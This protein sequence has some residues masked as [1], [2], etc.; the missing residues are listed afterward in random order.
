[1]G[2]WGSTRW[3]GHPPKLVVEACVVLEVGMLERV[4]CFRSP[5][6]TW[7]WARSATGAPVLSVLVTWDP[8]GPYRLLRLQYVVKG[9]PVEET[10][11]LTATPQPF[12]GVRWWFHCPL[13]VAENRP[14]L[15]RQRKLYLPPGGRYFGCRSCYDLAYASQ[16]DPPHLRPWWRLEAIQRR[17]GGS[18]TGPLPPRPKGMSRRTYARWVSAY[19]EAKRQCVEEWGARLAYFRSLHQRSP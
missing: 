12:G 16:Q 13:P 8:R 9:E 17:L 4:G 5:S 6:P 10:V 7:G 3:G 14:C 15:K 18:P 2:G 11:L 19:Q 1:M